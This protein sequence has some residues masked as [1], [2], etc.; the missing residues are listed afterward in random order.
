MAP[1]K[2]PQVVGWSH[3]DIKAN[4]SLNETGV[5]AG[6]DPNKVGLTKGGGVIP[7]PLLTGTEL[8]KIKEC[9][10]NFIVQLV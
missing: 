8:G 4:L 9:I 1:I 6:T 5:V 3:S 10:P 7:P 2:L